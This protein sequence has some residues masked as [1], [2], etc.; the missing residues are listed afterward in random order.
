[1]LFDVGTGKGQKSCGRNNSDQVLRFKDTAGL[2]PQRTNDN[3]Q[4]RTWFS[5]QLICDYLKTSE[6]ARKSL[7]IP[8][9]KPKNGHT[10]WN[11]ILF[12][13]DYREMIEHLNRQIRLSLRCENNKSCNFSIGKLWT[14][15][16]AV[17]TYRV[18]TLNIAKFTTST[19]NHL[20][21]Q[22]SV[23]SVRAITISSTFEPNCQHEHSKHKFIGNVFFVRT[24]CVTRSLARRKAL[25]K[26]SAELVISVLNAS[27]YVRY[28]SISLRN[29]PFDA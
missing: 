24:K 14:T 9:P 10:K 11:E 5:G 26:H 21:L 25:F 3:F 6:Q 19:R 17:N 8:L 16:Q 13:Y 20:T 28:V 15:W 12:S 23:K 22:R 18:V 27:W 4:K 7:E 1:M 2:C 29:V